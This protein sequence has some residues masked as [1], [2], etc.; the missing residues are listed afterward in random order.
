MG[1]GSTP[2]LTVH[3]APPAAKEKRDST[4][5]ILAW[6]AVLVWGLYLVHGAFDDSDAQRLCREHVYTGCFTQL[7]EHISCANNA[8]AVC[9]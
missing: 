9:E 1:M 8:N 4:I 2:H 7:G 5:A 3:E 6:L